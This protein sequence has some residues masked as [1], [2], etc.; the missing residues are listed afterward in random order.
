MYRILI[1]DDHVLM[2]KGMR[3]LIESDPNWEICAEAK[4]GE[5][6]VRLAR[7]LRPDLA[8]VDISM[9]L[10]NGL[11]AA[12]MI[13]RAGLAHRVLLFSTY[14]SPELISEARKIG[15]HGY[16]SKAIGEQGLIDAMRSVLNGELVFA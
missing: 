12:Q 10:L 15:V 6:A 7:S 14:E 9:P 3:L 5:E 1:A 8:V 2:R 4:D 11:E 13:L 16:V